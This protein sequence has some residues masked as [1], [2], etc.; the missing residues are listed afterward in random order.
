MCWDSMQITKGIPVH[1]LEKVGHMMYTVV[2]RCRRDSISITTVLELKQSGRWKLVTWYTDWQEKSIHVVQ[3]RF[4][5]HYYS[6]GTRAEWYVEAGHVTYIHRQTYTRQPDHGARS[7]QCK[8]PVVWNSLP[9]NIRLCSSLLSFKA[10][11]KAHFFCTP[12]CTI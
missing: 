9:L 6:I 7:F 3:K 1:W 4:N 5:T 10:Q 12:F 2:T 11:L 8:A